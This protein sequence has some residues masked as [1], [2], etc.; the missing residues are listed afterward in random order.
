MATL[1]LL[2]SPVPRSALGLK[3]PGVSDETCD[4]QRS[5]INLFLASAPGLYYIVIPTVLRLSKAGNGGRSYN[6]FSHRIQ[7]HLFSVIIIL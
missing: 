1:S 7:I 2:L 4:S 3:K 6:L 5:V